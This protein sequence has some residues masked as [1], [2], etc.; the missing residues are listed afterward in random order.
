MKKIKFKPYLPLLLLLL[1]IACLAAGFGTAKTASAETY[2]NY[3]HSFYFKNY[4]VTYDV[5]SNREISVTEKLEITFTGREST[6][7][8]KDIPVNAGETV[9]NVE[10]AEL[11]NGA[12][13]S[14]YY[15]VYSVK[16]DYGNPYFYVDIGDYSNKTNQTHTYVI[17]YVYCLTKAQEG[18]NILYLNAIG[19]DRDKNCHIESAT[20][21]LI[22]PDGYLS[23]K[24]FTGAALSENEESFKTHVNSDGRT[25]LT[26][27]KIPLEYDE[28]VTFK[29]TFEEGA[30][31]T[32]FDFTPYWFVIATAVILLFLIALKF[33][34]F[35]KRT[36]T[37]VI[38]FE[39]P[40]KMN[41]LLM[42]KLIDGKI[43]SED[44]TSMIFYWA[45]KG[46]LKINF[47]DQKD[48][49]LI[50]IVRAIPQD[51][52]DYE[53]IMFAEM[54]DGQDAIKPSMLRNK[55][56]RTTDKVAKT[57]NDRTKGLYEKKS[58][59]ISIMLAVLAGLMLGLTPLLLAL[60]QISLR[61]LIIA[62]FIAIIPLMFAYVFSM[63]LVNNKYKSKKGI[64]I[65][66]ACAAIGISLITTLFYTLLVP[67]F[68]LGVV[69]KILL[70]LVASATACLSVIIITRTQSYTEQLNEIVGFRN[71]IELTEKDK[72][73]KLLEEDPQFYYHVLPYAQ[74][75]GVS[76][77]W[78]DKFKDI[79]VQ[80]P[81]WATSSTADTLLN[82]YIFNSI[83][84]TSMS[85]MTSNFA[86]RP[87]SSGSSG[88]GGFSG[89]GGHVG[90]GHGGGGFHGR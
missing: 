68:I 5:K 66:F 87:S 19:V 31:S 78:E 21:M 70:C 61:Y 79:T 17:N 49:T 1:T 60:T 6:G 63:G 62:P 76:D 8:M 7:F 82:F 90:G 23:G 74:V 36:L 18:D 25:V 34:A 40:N 10:V 28:G 54:F 55:F 81:Q 73:E 14:V 44:I 52:P 13:H 65:G 69:P 39:A 75:L 33:L 83:M 20:V 57:V 45:D 35:N 84:R 56:Y 15:D 43:D 88:F 58:V 9:K 30:L 59:I 53:Q 38:N 12:K 41:P 47:D 42:G 2:D 80:P 3:L 37:P 46:Y 24:C 64:K 27:E 72:L 71:F 67:S 89:G 48:P 77:K 29:L 85:S 11:V 32:Y 4:E 51:A 26:L 16:D 22:L 50:R 86:S